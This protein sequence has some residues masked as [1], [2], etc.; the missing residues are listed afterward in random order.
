MDEINDEKKD[1]DICDKDKDEKVVENKIDND[2]GVGNDDKDENE[3]NNEG[4]NEE[5][6]EENKESEDENEEYEDYEED[7][8]E[9]DD[10]TIQND[11]SCFYGNISTSLCFDELVDL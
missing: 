3:K 4:I 9:Y 8:D 7:D 10:E 2:T 6:N 1:N 5:N 11:N